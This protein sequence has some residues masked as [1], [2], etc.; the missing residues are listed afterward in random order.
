[1]T[2]KLVEKYIKELKMLRDI[3][4]FH[5]LAEKYG[6]LSPRLVKEKEEEQRKLKKI[7]LGRND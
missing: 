1:M 4:E 6:F 5:L 3:E 7:F 2:E